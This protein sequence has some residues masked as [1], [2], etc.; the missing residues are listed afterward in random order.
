MKGKEIESPPMRV[1][2]AVRLNALI[3]NSISYGCENSKEENRA[4]E[5]YAPRAVSSFSIAQSRE[6]DGVYPYVRNVDKNVYSY[7]RYVLKSEDNNDIE[8]IVEMNTWG[9]RL[10]EKSPKV[11]SGGN[12]SLEIKRMSRWTR[13][14]MIEKTYILE[15]SGKKPSHMLTLTVPPKCWEK[16]ASDED[17]FEVWKNAK[18]KMLKDISK[19]MYRKYGDEWGSNWWLEFQ[20]RGAPHI[21]MLLE[22][23]ELKKREWAQWLGWFVK[24]W[25]HALGQDSIPNQA[26]DF[27]KMKYQDFRYI[28][29]YASKMRQKEAPFV[30]E[31]GR[32]WGCMGSWNRAKNRVYRLG[33]VL[34]KQIEN[35]IEKMMVSS[36]RFATT[37]DKW[38]RGRISGLRI[39]WQQVEKA[40]E[41]STLAEYWLNRREI[42]KML[43]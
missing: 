2:G 19:R 37:V 25:A 14:R 26:V 11:K 15:A 6:A 22:M 20:E 27:G 28:R 5:A 1:G 8:L 7:K 23:G 3:K 36:R 41:N 12:R 34:K 9:V 33:K 40:K 16:Q 31:W 21:H 38:I 29:K 32:W 42:A 18:R 17:R 4:H 30:A 10:R 39:Y 43:C 35:E 13:R 24:T